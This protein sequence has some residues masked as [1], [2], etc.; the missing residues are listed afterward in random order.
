MSRTTNKNA[1]QTDRYGRLP[2]VSTESQEQ[3]GNSQ[4]HAEG[5][6]KSKSSAH[7]GTGT[8]VTG[9]RGNTPQRRA[10]KDRRPVDGRKVPRGGPRQQRSKQQHS[11]RKG[12]T[13]KGG[14]A[15]AMATPQHQTHGHR[16][17]EDKYTS[18]NHQ[19]HMQDKKNKSDEHRAKHTHRRT[20][21]QVSNNN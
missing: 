3:A 17:E 21:G 10:A 20:R 9:E 12:Q 15:G 18:R 14:R 8:L 5:D 1:R 19:Q 11:D 13:G 6:K 7:R 16:K 2:L 4:Q